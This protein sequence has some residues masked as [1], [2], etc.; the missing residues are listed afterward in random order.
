M[1]AL[2]LI[3]DNVMA[4]WPFIHPSLLTIFLGAFPPIIWLFFFLM[5]DNIQPEPKR[6]VFKVFLIGIL[7]AFVAAAIEYIVRGV[8]LIPAGVGDYSN[9]TFITFAF[10]EELVKFMAVYL[11]VKG[12]KY[13]DEPVD[14]MIYMITGALGFAAIENVLFLSQQPSVSLLEISIV[15]SIGATLLHAIAGG[16]IGYYWAKKK[17]MVGLLL[18]VGLHAIFNYAIFRLSYSA[19]YAT[20]ILVVASFFVFYYFDIIKDEDGQ[21]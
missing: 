17:I 8:I 12:S 10:I 13:F 7:A 5:E 1:V 16:L 14:Y 2:H 11:A 15:R 21:Q 4:L 3:Q 18:A 19:V 20:G 9:I 6:M